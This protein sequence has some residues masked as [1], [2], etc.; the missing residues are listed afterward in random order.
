MNSSFHAPDQNHLVGDNATHP[1]EPRWQK[2]DRRGT[3]PVARSSAHTGDLIGSYLT[4]RFYH[5]AVLGR[6]ACARGPLLRYW[7]Y[8]LTSSSD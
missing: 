5:L 4:I 3:N 8:D 6:A 2:A 1:I 7:L